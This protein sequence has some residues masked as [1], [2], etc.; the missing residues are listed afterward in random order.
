MLV[1]NKPVLSCIN[2]ES[3]CKKTFSEDLWWVQSWNNNDAA[4][5]K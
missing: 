5:S 4:T 2:K 1:D 3:K